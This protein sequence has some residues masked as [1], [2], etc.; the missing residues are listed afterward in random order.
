MKE[1]MKIMSDYTIVSADEVKDFYEDT[2]VPGEFRRLTKAK[3]PGISM[4]R[5]RKFM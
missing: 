2:D 4:M 5:L 3:A 1:K